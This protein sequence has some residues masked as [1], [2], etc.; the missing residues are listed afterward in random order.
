MILVRVPTTLV[1]QRNVIVAHN[2][3]QRDLALMRDHLLCRR[4]VYSTDHV[5]GS[6]IGASKR[7]QDIVLLSAEAC[8]ERSVHIL[9]DR[10][11][12]S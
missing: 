12:L 4:R 2:A 11:R 9:S 3:W 10:E 5:A 8:L 1:K 6:A 7:L